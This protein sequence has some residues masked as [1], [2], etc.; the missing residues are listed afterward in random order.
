MALNSYSALITA[1]GNWLERGDTAD[2]VPSWIALA[3]AHMNRRLRVNKML[4]RNASF[5]VDAEFESV[6]AD[7]LAPRSAR[8]TSGDKR[9]LQYYTPEQ[10]ADYKW[11]HNQ[12]G[13]LWAYAVVGSNFEFGPAPNDTYSIALTYY[14]KIPALTESNTSNWV[15]ASYPDAYLHGCLMYA[16]IYYIDA[17][18]TNDNATAF[19]AALDRIE[20][21]DRTSQFAANPT[22]TPSQYAV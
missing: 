12:A 7:F 8:L 10:M 3:E 2:L 18:M 9:L 6:P 4:T 22:P 5:S 14:G 13:T 21:E 20:A 1:V 15:L 11:A 16:G 19:T 17:E